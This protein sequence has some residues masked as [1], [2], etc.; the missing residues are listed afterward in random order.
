MSNFAT[1]ALRH[2]G[3]N[4]SFKRLSDYEE[5]LANKIVDAS[6]TV[7]KRLGPG[8]L[9]KIMVLKELFSNRLNLV[10]WCLSG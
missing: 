4:M 3:N 9:E 8:L 5:S 7:H 10:S 2:E 1:K 6:Y